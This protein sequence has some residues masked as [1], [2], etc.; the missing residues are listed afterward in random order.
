MYAGRR[1]A[2]P[3]AF[4]QRRSVPTGMCLQGLRASTCSVRAKWGNIGCF[5]ATNGGGLPHGCQVL[6]VAHPGLGDRTQSAI[7]FKL[8]AQ[9]CFVFSR[10]P[11]PGVRLSPVLPRLRPRALRVLKTPTLQVNLWSWSASRD[12]SQPRF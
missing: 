5:R 3:Q 12:W 1:L 8:R 11:L 6:G 7:E 4:A 10:R 9:T 2:K